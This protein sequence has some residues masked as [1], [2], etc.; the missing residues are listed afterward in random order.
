MFH[1]NQHQSCQFTMKYGQTAADFDVRSVSFTWMSS[2]D[3]SILDK[4][5]SEFSN[6]KIVQWKH[7]LSHTLLFQKCKENVVFHD[8]TL[9]R[10][11]LTL[12]RLRK[13]KFVKNPDTVHF[14]QKHTIRNLSVEAKGKKKISKTVLCVTPVMC[15]TL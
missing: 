12:N 6:L 15:K 13:L 2:D 8:M 5:G 11:F 14:G 4:L 9:W 1:F 10:Q 3:E 7:I